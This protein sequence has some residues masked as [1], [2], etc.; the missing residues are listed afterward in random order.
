MS[1]VDERKAK[2]KQVREQLFGQ[3]VPAS[4]PEGDPMA[5]F[6]DM[7]NEWIFGGVWSRPGLEMKQREMIVLAV[8]T[9]LGRESEL[10]LHLGAALN[11]GLTKEQI[12]EVLTQV[13]FYAGVPTAV[14][15]FRI[16]REVLAQAA[17]TAA[18]RT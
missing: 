14:S 9:A 3:R 6:Y 4:F 15:G 1:V 18:Q 5:D 10:R 11:L 12:A 13:G 17:E 8:L 2:A 7:I 16:F